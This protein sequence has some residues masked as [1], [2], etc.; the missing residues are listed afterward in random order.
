MWREKGRAVSK[1]DNLCGPSA[2]RW[3]MSCPELWLYPRT[4]RANWDLCFRI[5][6]TRNGLVPILHLEWYLNH[7]SMLTQQS[8]SYLTESLSQVCMQNT[9]L[10]IP[11]FFNK[12]P[13]DVGKGQSLSILGC[14]SLC[15][16][17]FK[18]LVFFAYSFV[19]KILVLYQ[20][21]RRWYQFWLEI[22]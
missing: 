10:G 16:N 4:V 20:C 11:S 7:N 18:S 6:F 13:H 2:L 21:K 3:C 14:L 22:I 9:V 19:T 17:Q 1:G 12:H 15:E 8:D 5:L